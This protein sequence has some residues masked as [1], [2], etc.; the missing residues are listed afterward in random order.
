MWTNLRNTL[1]ASLDLL[2]PPACLLCGHR[3]D[4]DGDKTSF[5]RDCLTGMTP[6]GEAH[7][8]RCA[9]P[10]PI[11][12]AA[13]HLCGNCLQQPP[14]FSCIYAAGRYQGGFSD[15][16][17]RLK[18]RNQLS[19][20]APLG[21]RLAAALSGIGAESR[22]EVVIPV[23]LHP[24][25]LRQRGYNQA[26][27]LSRSVGR[28]FNCPIAPLLLQRVRHTP[29]QQGLSAAERRGNLRN[30]FRLTRSVHNQVILLIDDVM[31]TGE[32][33]RECSRALR[34]GGAAEV[35][36]AVVARA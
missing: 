17:N 18:Y 35:M 16:I 29:P 19:L 4:P 14:P 20:A 9:Q 12:E 23:P 11:L 25:R 28:A 3:L 6:L 7:C 8:R 21:R 5:C 10:Y 34:N 1:Q 32:T 31:T 27:E 2:L 33:V 30:A 15:A 36:V 13:D 26:M 22:P 24:S